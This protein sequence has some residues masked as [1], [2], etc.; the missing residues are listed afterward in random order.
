ME[1]LKCSINLSIWLQLKW[2][3]TKLN[4]MPAQYLVTH[5]GGLKRVCLQVNSAYI[6]LQC[7]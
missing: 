7:S 4:M 6:A 2:Y 3:I 5:F 1:Y